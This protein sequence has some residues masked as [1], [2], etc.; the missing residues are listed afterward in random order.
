VSFSARARAERPVRIGWIFSLCPSIRSKFTLSMVAVCDDERWRGRRGNRG[1]WRRCSGM[2]WMSCGGVLLV[3]SSVGKA[4]AWHLGTRS[5]DALTHVLKR[6][7]CLY[8]FLIESGT[9]SG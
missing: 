5:A 2:N 6:T 3:Y 7:A 4:S 1:R 9:E 8:L